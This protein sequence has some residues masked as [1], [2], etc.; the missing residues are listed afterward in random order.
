[1]E[2]EQL[3]IVSKVIV[4][5]GG[6][7][8]VFLAKTTK[9]TFC[10][11][12]VL[13]RCLDTW[14][15]ELGDVIGCLPAGELKVRG[16]LIFLWIPVKMYEKIGNHVISEIYD[17]DAGHVFSKTGCRIDAGYESRRALSGQE[18]QC[19]VMEIYNNE[20][21]YYPLQLISTVQ[22]D[23]QHDND[24]HVVYVIRRMSGEKVISSA[25][26]VRAIVDSCTIVGSKILERYVFPVHQLETIQGSVFT[27]Q[28]IAG[29]LSG[30]LI[31]EREHSVPDKVNYIG[32]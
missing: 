1:M 4:G 12:V 27:S 2:K 5:H 8:K 25:I 14:N 16:D 17:R 15:L 31:I 22:V 29:E 26:R 20:P 21:V 6:D 32:E 24:G 13:R 19:R 23:I 10:R 28:E 7:K 11:D 30:C 3:F 18:W 9:S